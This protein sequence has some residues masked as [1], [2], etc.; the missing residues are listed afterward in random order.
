MQLQNGN[1]VAEATSWRD[2]LERILAS[3]SFAGASRMRAL[4]GYLV[5]E[6]LAG[7]GERLKEY[8]VGLEVFG[9]GKDF[10]PR[11]DTLVRTE[12]WRL[13]TRLAQYYA[14]EGADN[15]VRIELP[16]RSF[17][18]L[19]RRQAMPALALAVSPAAAPANPAEAPLR[20]VLL[21]FTVRDIAPE[22]FGL[23]AGI[24]EEL[25]VELGGRRLQIVAREIAGG[26]EECSLGTGLESV[27]RKLGVRWALRGAL[28]HF[29]G[30]VRSSA[31]LI[32]CSSGDLVWAHA[33]SHRFTDLL[34]LQQAVASELADAFLA[35]PPAQALDLGEPVGEDIA[36]DSF[37]PQ[38]VRWDFGA[39]R[40]SVDALRRR[41]VRL[42]GWVR[43]RPNDVAARRQ[44]TVALARFVCAVPPSWDDLAPRLRQTA[45]GVLAED[46]GAV[47]VAIALGMALTVG[48]QWEAAG[49]A[50]DQAVAQG[51]D[52]ADALLARGLCRIHLGRLAEA[53]DDLARARSLEPLSAVTTATLGLLRHHERRFDEAAALARTALALD[54]AF[55]PAQLL[56]ADT[57][58]CAGRMADGLAQLH[59]AQRWSGRWPT[60]LGRLGHVYARMDRG[61]AAGELLEELDAAPAE[62][63]SHSAIAD[64]QLGLG[65]VDAALEALGRAVEARNLRELMLYSAPRFDPL[66]REA[67]FAALMAHMHLPGHQL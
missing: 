63:R 38:A 1:D 6:T 62:L 54:P 17:I 21:P 64:I 31:Q 26:S 48:Y 67:R 22:A 51:S 9:R 29:G 57:D 36:A 34:Q 12:A 24:A 25:G 11:I 49:S 3:A 4:L 33:A 44:L 47:E 66:R 5:R 40:R 28:Q 15:P 58:L 50:L 45:T 61:D 35:S 65:N 23:G 39:T 8:T 60:V 10:D 19:L 53:A 55:E 2:E 27:S 46:P 43:D 16:R 37:L 56:L 42:Q 20:M 52:N 41:V 30:V 7:R 14:G 59:E 18:A 32:D 13:R